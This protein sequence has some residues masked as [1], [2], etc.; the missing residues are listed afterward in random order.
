MTTRDAVTTVMV[1]VGI[2]GVFIYYILALFFLNT[3]LLNSPHS[4]HVLTRYHI[5]FFIAFLT[6]VIFSSSVLA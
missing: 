5:F 6:V 2:W 3:P 1:M 4:M